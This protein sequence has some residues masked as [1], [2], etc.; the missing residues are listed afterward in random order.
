MNEP[1][2]IDLE[3]LRTREK[4]VSRGSIERA[5]TAAEQHGFQPGSLSV[6]AGALRAL[7]RAECMP[8]YCQMSP[9]RLP[10]RPSVVVFSKVC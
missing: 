6:G 4:D 10:T 7:G 9:K 5:D 8:R 2:K 3:A 1:F